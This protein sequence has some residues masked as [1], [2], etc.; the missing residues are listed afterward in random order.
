MK[1]G[2]V[3]RQLIG[4]G[5]KSAYEV[6]AGSDACNINPALQLIMERIML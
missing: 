2:S 6:I 1:F 3:G 4:I 5:N